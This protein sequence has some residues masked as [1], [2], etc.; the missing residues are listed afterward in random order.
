MIKGK[1]KS[2]FQFEI[3]DEDLTNYDL[4]EVMAEVDT[5]QLL[6]PRLLKLLL[7]EDQK[8]ALIDHIR[9][10]SGRVPLDTLSEVVAEIFATGEAKNS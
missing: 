10:E 6:L 1:T 5:N 2:G 9:D 4:L 7:G 8:R 3:K